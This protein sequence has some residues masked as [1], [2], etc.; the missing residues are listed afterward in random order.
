MTGK[1][2]YSH[3][4]INRRTAIQAGSIG[5]MGLGMNHL[6]ALREA[7]ASPVLPRVKAKSVIYIFLSGGLSQQ[8]SFDMKPNA[9]ADIRG[10]FNPIPTSTPGIEICEHLPLLARRSHLWS[11]VRSLTHKHNE[12]SQGHMVMLSGRS[13]VSPTFNPTKPTPG[14]GPPSPRSREKFYPRPITY[15]PRWSF[16]KS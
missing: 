16:R 11:L 3:P 5:L 4:Q 2:G 12:H 6:T 13:D 8:D 10:E 15:L 9:P 14:T 1:F 7:T